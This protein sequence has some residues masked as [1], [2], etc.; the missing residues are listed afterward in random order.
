MVFGA[1][2]VIIPVSIEFSAIIAFIAAIIADA[3]VQKREGQFLQDC[4]IQ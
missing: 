4:I 2:M 3:L 1:S